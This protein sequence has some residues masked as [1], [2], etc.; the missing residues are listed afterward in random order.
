MEDCTCKTGEPMCEDCSDFWTD[1][2]WNHEPSDLRE[3]C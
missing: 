1:L 2:A 3:E